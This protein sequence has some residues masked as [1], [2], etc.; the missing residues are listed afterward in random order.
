MQVASTSATVITANLERVD[1]APQ[2]YLAGSGM[3]QSSGVFTFPSTGIWL[4]EIYT[5]NFRVE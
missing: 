1:T 4:V 2:G 5:Y 3:S